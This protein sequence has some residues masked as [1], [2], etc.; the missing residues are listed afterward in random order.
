[1][2]FF[3]G[4]KVSRIGRLPV[5]IPS[6]VSVEIQN[7]EVHVKGPKGELKRAF[8]PIISIAIKDKNVVVQRGSEEAEARA[9]HGTTRA[10]IQ[11]MVTGV[12]N[13]FYKVLEVEGVGYRAEMNGKNLVLYVGFSHPVEV[14]PPD[15]ILFEAD[16]KARTI[17]ISGRDREVVGQIAADIRKIRPPEPYKGKGLRYKGERVR[18]KAGKSGKAKII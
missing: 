8:S 6:G 7:N 18:R 5:E 12:S 1:M 2:Q 10:L 15:G 11:N 4:L 9:L 17:T 16:T 14:E 13:G 3:G